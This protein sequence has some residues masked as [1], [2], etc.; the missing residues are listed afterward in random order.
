M[1]IL[2]SFGGSRGYG[3]VGVF[4]PPKPTI[5][6]V[7][8]VGTNRAFNDGALSVT[9]SPDPLG[10]TPDYY[11]S[12]ALDPQN[13]IAGTSS[14]T[15]NT[16]FTISNLQSNVQYTV[17]VVA[18]FNYVASQ[19]A[20]YTTPTLVTTVPAEPT[21]GTATDVG[22]NRAITDAAANVTFTAG[23]TG[24]KSQTFKVYTADGTQRGTGSGSPILAE[25]IDIGEFGDGS[26]QSFRVRG[27]NANGDSLASGTTSTITLTSTPGPT[28]VVITSISGSVVNFSYNASETG[29]KAVTSV[30]F[31]VMSNG[32]QLVTKTV[33]STSGTDSLTLPNVS[34]TATLYA[35]ATNSNGVGTD[36]A[37]GTVIYGSQAATLSPARVDSSTGTV[38]IDNYNAAYTYTVTTASGSA[39]RTNGTVTITGAGTDAFNVTV[40]VNQGSGYVDT[41]TTT[42]VPAY[43][44]PPPFFPPYFPIVLGRCTSAQV[45]AGCFSTSACC[46]GG[47]GE[48]CSPATSGCDF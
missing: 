4:V 29:G 47:A 16:T 38:T 41:S 6:S 12:W 8:D 40:K 32:S 18:V 28:T 3:R 14:S 15:S 9:V 35:T 5:V 26:S 13:N 20:T 19:Y 31:F 46:D 1:G 25:G 17:Q 42:T 37:A 2:G 21:I 36:T 44:A 39:S 43:V 48:A 22:T 24:G 11:N 10:P 23:A 30:R 34:G 27:V 45:V 7:T 33:S